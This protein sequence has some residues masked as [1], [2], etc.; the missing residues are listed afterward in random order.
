MALIL[1]RL[2]D[3]GDDV[4]RN[5]FEFDPTYR[6]LFQARVK[7]GL[8][9]AAWRNW[10]AYSEECACPF[11]AV[12]MKWLF[13]SW[14]IDKW[15]QPGY[16][17]SLDIMPPLVF[18]KQ[19][20]FPTDIRVVNRP[21][22]NNAEALLDAEALGV[23]GERSKASSAELEDTAHYV[24]IYVDDHRVLYCLVLT[25]EYYEDAY[26][27]ITDDRESGFH[28]MMDVFV[29]PRAGMVVLI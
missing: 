4:L 24:S 5:I 6:D 16:D 18:F 8:W 28:N 9:G 26:A 14:G 29:D 20:Y 3:L 23:F 19:Q 21:L 11:V 1:H 2:S 13:Q 15:G 22:L 7:D 25:T 10:Y 12:A 17:P 27:A